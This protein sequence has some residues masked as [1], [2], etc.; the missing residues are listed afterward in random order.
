MNYLHACYHPGTS[1]KFFIFGENPEYVS[2]KKR[3]RKPSNL[4]IRHPSCLPE[5]VVVE[6]LQKMDHRITAEPEVLTLMLPIHDNRPLS[7]ADPLP[8]VPVS[9]STVRVQAVSIGMPDLLLL[10]PA[11]RDIPSETRCTDSLLFFRYAFEFALELVSREQFVPA[12]EEEQ[13][14]IGNWSAVIQGE[15]GHRLQ[16]LA[17]LMPLICGS[18]VDDRPDSRTLV[19]RF[20]HEIVNALV[21]TSCTSQSSQLK[22]RAASLDKPAAAWYRALRGDREARS[23]PSLEDKDFIGAVKTWLTPGPEDSRPFFTCIRLAEPSDELPEFSIE[24]HLQAS[25]DPSLLV[26][27]AEVWKRRSGSFTYLNHRFE[28]PQEQLLAD[29]FAVGKIFPPVS[30]ALKSRAPVGITLT[31]EEASSFLT[32]YATIFQQMGVSVLLPSWWKDATKKPRFRLQVH[33]QKAQGKK[34]KVKGFFSFSDL[35]SYKWEIAIGDE[36][37]SADEF[38]TLVKLKKPLIHIGGKWAA[39]NPDELQRAVR[40]FQKQ[41]PDGGIPAMDALK[42]GLTGENSGDP[43]EISCCDEKSRDYLGL[44]LGSESAVP[45]DIPVPE[46]FRGTLRPYQVTGLSWLSFM[47]SRGLGTCLADDMGLGKTIQVIAYFL[48]LKEQQKASRIL[49]IAPMSLLGNWQREI[50]RFSPTLSVHIHHGPSRLQGK[51]FTRVVRDFDV[52]LTTYQ[53][54]QRDESLFSSEMW[55]VMVLDEA[56]NIKNNEARQTRAVKQ[57][58]APVRIALT[59][60]PVENRLMELWSI[61]DF[62]NPGYLGQPTGFVRNYA[63][64]IEKYHDRDAAEKLQ[65]LVK[66][67]VLRRVKTDRSIISD[68]P[69]KNIQKRYCTLTPEQATLYQ[70]TVD[71]M[72]KDVEHSEGITRRGIILTALLRL[73][74]ICNHPNAYLDD[75]KLTQERSGK[76]AMLFTLLEEVIASGDAAILFTQFPAFGKR[77]LTLMQNHFHE[78]VL[79]L[80]G[81]TPRKERDELVRRFS[82]PHGPRLFLLS[83]KAG[84]VG[85]NLTRANHVFH[86][87]RWWNPAVEDQATDR[88]YR[89]GQ[90]RNVAVHLLISAGTLEERI[91]MMIEEKRR[92]A[93]SVIG[94]GED[95]ITSLSTDELRDILRLSGECI[96][97]E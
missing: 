49:L 33:A 21:I 28:R 27:A 86:I 91:D 63:T 75:G 9:F 59:G 52:I 68:L 89:I 14:G 66:P 43:V 55:D 80:Y 15:D 88:V 26:S 46:T 37:I 1:P 39:F 56:Q 60:T 79:F 2:P 84:G 93:E 78:E 32:E 42:L 95:W 12:W 82:S 58:P 20:I 83:L 35:L 40:A 76:I 73:K 96:G 4:T 97:G 3:G 69:E 74:Q 72:L 92:L 24:F 18:F 31:S 38:E 48:T 81:D 65:A 94:T 22:G 77:L 70:A 53:M 19:T 47:T 7:P 62:I 41:Y 51:E 87:D 61:M 11:L 10:L 54:I 45:T 8:D 36:V 64:P 44:L 17:L 23:A 50:S 29:L 34:S 5:A 90:G 25:D 30:N 71:G 6:L 16:Q 85:L 57:I 13:G 67:F